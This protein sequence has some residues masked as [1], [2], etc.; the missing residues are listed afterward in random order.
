MLKLEPFKNEILELYNSGHTV[1]EIASRFNCYNQPVYNLIKKYSKL[2]KRDQ[3]PKQNP[4]DTKYFNNIDSDIKAYI[5]G[6][7]AAD[8]AIVKRSHR[9]EHQ[10][11]IT[12]HRKDKSI[13]DKI[14]DE[15]GCEHSITNINRPFS[16]DPTKSTDHVRLVQSNKH[17]IKDLINLGIK[18][19]KSLSMPN[20]ILNIP[21]QHR[22]SFILGY[23]DG[24]GSFTIQKF[25]DGKCLRKRG[26]VQIRGTKELLLGIADEL[27]LTSYSLSKKD[28]ICNLSIGS[29]QNIKTFFSIY[30]NN[31][32][33]LDRKYSK[34]IEYFN[35][36][37]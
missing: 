9:D 11:T 5:V 16:H 29:K 30:S 14:K 37:N 22:K 32:F 25:Q 27:Q 31:N 18:P 4:G 2:I 21:K 8:G 26:Y 15:I 7:I 1:K 34:F 13:L 35:M 6:F 28:K 3:K 12:I 10:L 24:D 36:I 17:I 33:Y 19:K 23:F 20:L